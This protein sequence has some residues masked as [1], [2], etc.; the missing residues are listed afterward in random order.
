MTNRPIRQRSYDDGRDR[1]QI[2]EACPAP[3][4]AG[5]VD[6]YAAWTERTES[7]TTRRELAS[8]TGVFIVNLGAPLQ[9]VD[10]RGDTHVF[11][12]GEGFVGGLAEATS[13][14]R[15]TGEMAGVHVH[16]P[17]PR[18][19][20]LFDA[21]I[22]DLR[23][24]VVRL[25]ALSGRARTLAIELLEAGDTTARFAML[26]RF[27]ASRA[28]TMRTDLA[29]DAALRLLARPGPRT[30][31]RAAATLQWSRKRLAQHVRD[32]TGLL[33]GALVRLS[34]FE[35]F[36]AALQ[37]APHYGLARHAAEAGYADQAHLTRD[38]RRL[39]GTTPLDLRTR[40]I[41][42]GGGIADG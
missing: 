26:D 4:L 23:D 14:S 12:A 34:R 8:T 39:A 25:D 1:W 6:R 11:A 17:V 15:S 13:L 29:V 28:G 40:L 33:P 18:L 7:F 41:P 5:I 2:A 35:R 37:T 27:V 24:R 10:A 22:A 42:A 32:A 19:A 3:A 16:M 20:A 36:V 38:V 9:I 31:E 30:V 21:G